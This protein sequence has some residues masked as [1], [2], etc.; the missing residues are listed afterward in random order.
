[1]TSNTYKVPAMLRE[2]PWLPLGKEAR[3]ARRFHGGGWT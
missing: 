1:M 3:L 2:L